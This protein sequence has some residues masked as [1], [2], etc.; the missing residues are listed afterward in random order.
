MGSK[1][2]VCVPRIARRCFSTIANR[3][4]TGWTFADFDPNGLDV[5]GP[6]SGAKSGDL[7]LVRKRPWGDTES[8]MIGW[9][10]VNLAGL[11]MPRD[12]SP[13][14]GLRNHESGLADMF[15]GAAV[16][17][18]SLR[19]QV[20]HWRGRE[21][22]LLPSDLSCADCEG[23]ERPLFSERGR[24]GGSWVSSVLALSSGELSGNSGVDGNL[25]HS[26][27]GPAPDW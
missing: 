15:P 23:E 8:T 11:D 22:S 16:A 12:E 14:G 18:S 20:L 4:T 24:G 7:I 9:R 17:G 19:W 26:F 2:C 25:E 21:W 13:F 27:A 6:R 5:C 1:A 3:A 10:S